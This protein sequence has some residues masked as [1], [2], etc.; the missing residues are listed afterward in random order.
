MYGSRRNDVPVFGANLTN[1]VVDAG[2]LDVTGVSISLVI[3]STGAREH[4]KRR[5]GSRR[6]EPV[7]IVVDENGVLGA[8]V[9]LAGVDGEAAG[10]FLADLADD[11]LTVDEERS[12]SGAVEFGAALDDG[13]FPLVI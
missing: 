10:V 11:L 3:S 5:V 12:P 6:R 7:V 9:S 8:V 13:C 4:L 2:V 1:V